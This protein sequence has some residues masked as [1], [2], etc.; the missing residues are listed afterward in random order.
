[1]RN[2][3]KKEDGV[4]FIRYALLGV[5]TLLASAAS[6]ALWPTVARVYIGRLFWACLVVNV[7][8]DITTGRRLKPAGWTLLV[9][10]PTLVMIWRISASSY[11]GWALPVA[12][13]YFLWRYCC[14]VPKSSELEWSEDIELDTWYPAQVPFLRIPIPWERYKLGDGVVYHDSIQK[15]ADTE[16]FGNIKNWDMS[17]SWYRK[18]AGTATF[19]ILPDKIGEKALEE[20]HNMPCS[21]AEALDKALVESKRKK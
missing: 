15:V 11:T 18:A 13:A 6:A 12:A 16:V 20:W 10:V 14:L 3:P 9:A 8:A 17:S 7:L 1:M 21:F 5:V 4:R 19:R 2:F